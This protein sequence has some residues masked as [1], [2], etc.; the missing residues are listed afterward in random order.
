MKNPDSFYFGF[1]TREKGSSHRRKWNLSLRLFFLSFYLS[2]QAPPSLINDSTIARYRY[3]TIS[4]QYAEISDGL[5]L[6]DLDIQE[7]DYLSPQ[8]HHALVCSGINANNAPFFESRTL[9]TTKLEE[10]LEPA[11]LQLITPQASYGYDSLGGLSYQFDHNAEELASMQKITSDN[12]TDGWQPILQFFPSKHDDFVQNAINSGAHFELFPDNSFKLSYSAHWMIVNPNDR[13]IESIYD[14][15][16]RSYHSR[17]E[18][19]LLAPYGYVPRFEI[20]RIRRTDLPNPIT[21]VEKTLYKNHVIEDLGNKVEKYTDVSH[22]ELFPN[23]VEGLYEVLLKGLPETVV[24]QVLIRDY[25]GNTVHTH[26]NP[27]IAQDIMVLDASSYP[28]GTLIIMVYTPQ[29]IYSQ[30]LTKH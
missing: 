16:N 5:G 22:I 27:V 23:P 26:T 20:M 13:S 10:W 1:A 11:Y 12:T 15:E 29:G 14:Y 18:Y 17:V 28:S 24:S 30:T 8:S 3:E 19:L 21:L 6:E 4:H 7:R 25:M 2:A 9:S